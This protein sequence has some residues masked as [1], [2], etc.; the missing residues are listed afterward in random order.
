MAIKEVTLRRYNGTGTDT[1]MPTTTMAQVQVST[2]DTTSITD[3]LINNYINLTEKGAADGVA[4][5]D[6]NQKIPYSQLPSSILG[7]LKFVSSLSVNTDLDTLGAA[8]TTDTDAIGSYYIATADIEIT[9]TAFS[10]VLEP[11]DEGD[12][13]PP[14]SIE[15]GDWVIIT[16]WAVDNYTFAI[17]NNTYALATDTEKG[18][19]TLSSATDTTGTTSKVIT[20]NVLGGLIGTA[21]NTIA[22]GDHLHDDRYYTETEIGTFFDGST[23]ISGYNK[24]NWDTAYS[25]KINS[26][27]FNTADGVLTLTRQDNTTLTV[28]LDGRYVETITAAQTDSTTGIVIG[29]T[30]T[31]FTVAHSNTSSVGDVDNADGNVIQDMTFDTYGHVQT[32]TSVN[33]D[34]R[35]YTE[36]EINN[37]LGGTATLNGDSYTPIIYGTDPTSTITGAILID[38]D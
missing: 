13:T 16:D 28:D 22:A 30:G 4:T 11:G 26:T 17:I 19:V 10:T 35:Y 15:A 2:S 5:L 24:T 6:T 21:A 33:L 14:I 36:T 37:W 3:F 34:G 8:F 9:S 18:L 7:G 12:F 32:T 20:E 23:S 29:N 25:E 27:S 31:A 1:L 38:E